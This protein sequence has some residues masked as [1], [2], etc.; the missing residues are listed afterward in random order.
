MPHKYWK[1]EDEKAVK[2]ARSYPE[3]CTVAKRVLGRIGEDVCFVCGPITTGGAGS[4]KKNIV[5]LKRRITLLRKEGKNVFDQ[6]AFEKA[7]W[8]IEK[9]VRGSE[10]DLLNGFYRPLFELGKIKTFYFVFGWET[11]YG[12][13]WE[14]NQARRLGIRTVFLG[15]L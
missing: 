4:V 13:Q 2:L 8:R 9:L 6:M 15:K 12:A 14:Y 11:S 3:L 5:V 7:L 10:K 1:K